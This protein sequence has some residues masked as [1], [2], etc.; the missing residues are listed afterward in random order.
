MMAD[1]TAVEQY[2]RDLINHKL[3]TGFEYH[4]L[5]HTLDVTQR[6]LFYANEEGIT[7]HDVHLLQTAALF[8]D[9]GFTRTYEGHEQASAQIACEVLP[10]LGYCQSDIDQVTQLILATRRPPQP[11][12][13]LAEILCDADLD[14]LGRDDFVQRADSL[15]QEL[16]T[17]CGLQYSDQEWHQRLRSLLTSHTY[18]TV[19]ARKHRDAGKAQ[20][21]RD[22]AR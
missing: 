8:H 5:E 1:I 6:A 21:L 20:N 10:A 12:S 22:Q 7:A 18:F 9:T 19:S 3:R 11:C 4:N 2:V 17:I 15:R 14:N 16:Q 13:R